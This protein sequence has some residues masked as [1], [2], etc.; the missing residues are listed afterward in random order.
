METRQR[1]DMLEQMIDEGSIPELLEDISAICLDKAR[2]I[3]DN[4]Q[5]NET[6]KI[7]KKFYR[8]L[9]SVISEVELVK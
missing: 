9:E 3:Q 7:W 1:F 5:D 6:A 2:Y 4:L 8:I